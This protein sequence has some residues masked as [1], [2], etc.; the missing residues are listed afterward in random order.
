MI[1]ELFSVSLMTALVVNVAGILFIVE[2][3]V[4][5]DDGAGRVWSI[6]FLFGMLTTIAYGLWAAGD[7]GVLAV[8]VANACFTAS[9]GCW[10]LGARRFN[11]RT[12]VIGVFVLI[13]AALLSGVLVF[14]QWDVAGDWSGILAMYAS[15]AAFSALAA[16]E[17]FRRPMGRIRTAWALGVGLLLVGAFYIGRGAVFVV[18]GPGSELF[19]VYFGSV[20]ANMVT[21]MLAVVGVVVTS[22]L[23]SVNV[24]PRAF[25]WVSDSGIASDG[26]LLNSTFVAALRDVTERA[27]W[28]QELVAVVSV[29]VDDLGQI[30]TAFGSDVVDSITVAWRGGVRRFAPSN[31]LVGEDGSRGMLVCFVPATAAEARRHAAV[32]YRG[33]FEE[34]GDVSPGVIPVVG[35]GIALSDT[36]GHETDRLI[37]NAQRTARKAATSADS[38]VLFSGS[39]AAQ[40]G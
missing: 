36:V 7:G 38:S 22:V 13:A 30:A 23:R 16:I 28:R 1:L 19:R 14:V 3:L 35:V 37:A 4:R 20:A 39:D 29:R 24:E 2:T 5:R 18:A 25:A 26:I 27:G 11:Q 31:A 34:L 9:A 15:V 8:A 40:T 6:A 17:C 10:W 32:I 21:V 33:L 12:L